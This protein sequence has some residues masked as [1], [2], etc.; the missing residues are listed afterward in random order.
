MNKL[1]KIINEEL[2]QINEF[3]EASNDINPELSDLVNTVTSNADKDIRESTYDLEKFRARYEYA[4]FKIERANLIKMFVVIL[5]SAKFVYDNPDFWIKEHGKS[6]Y[7]FDSEYDIKH[8][9]FEKWY[10]YI[11]NPIHSQIKYFNPDNTF[12]QPT[13]INEFKKYATRLKLLDEKI[14]ILYKEIYEH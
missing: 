4:K 7:V 9:L 1:I 5:T 10:D 6:E 13:W 8:I 3:D 11:K 12:P 2:H 14:D